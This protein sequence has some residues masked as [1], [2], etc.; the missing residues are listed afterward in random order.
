VP[1]LPFYRSR[2]SGGYTREKE[3]R[4]EKKKEK[5]QRRRKPWSYV[6]LLPR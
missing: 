2:K 5:K 4:K 1:G 6:T 3:R